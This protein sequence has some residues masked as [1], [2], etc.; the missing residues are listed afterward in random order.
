MTRRTLL[1]RWHEAW[2]RPRFRIRIV[3]SFVFL[4]LMLRTLAQ[5]LLWVERRPGVVVPDPLL[6]AFPPTEM[7]WVIFTLVYLGIVMAVAAFSLDPDRL[8]LA[9]QTYALCIVFRIIAMYLLPLE[10]PAVTI[11]LK[12]P[13]VETFGSGQLLMKDLFF[14]GHTSV[15]FILFLTAARGWLKWT[16]FAFTLAAATAIIIH[17]THYSVDVFVAPFVAYTSYRIAVMVN[18]R[19]DPGITSY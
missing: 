5:F 19:Y 15:L 4:G 8:A 18:K 9:F 2:I 6:A 12:D 11:P 14:S 17:H 3:F 7:T 13:L 1:Y 10:P 16:F